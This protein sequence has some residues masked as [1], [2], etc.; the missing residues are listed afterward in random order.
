L[1]TLASGTLSGA[2][3]LLQHTHQYDT[4]TPLQEA[5]MLQ[6]VAAS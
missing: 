3:A 1:H 2:H 4:S 6:E 5:R